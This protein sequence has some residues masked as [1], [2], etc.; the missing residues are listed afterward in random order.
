LPKNNSP[1][2][3]EAA[4]RRTVLT[5]AL[6]AMM[7]AALDSSIVNTA[8]PRMVADL[9]G[10]THLS[11][12]VTAFMLSSTIT[13]PLYGKLSDTHGRRAMFAVSIG[14][15][16]LGSVLCGAARTMVEL[17]AFRAV[18]G[19][20]AGGLLV[21]AQAMIGD[22]VSPRDRPRYQGLFTGVFGLA[23][24]LGPLLGG[25]ITQT[26][27]WR[28]IFYV[29]LPVG[30]L[31]FAMIWFG[32]PATKR[33]NG[34]SRAKPIDYLGTMLLT[35]LTTSLLLL[36]A[37][38]GSQFRWESPDAL[39]MCLVTVLCFGLFLWREAHAP[40]P[41]IRLAL[42]RNPVI[43]RGSAVGGMVM[44]A[45]FGSLVF[46][47]LYFQ[48]VLGMS[49]AESGAMI[50]PQVGCM[51]L[52]SVIGGRI[53]ARLGRYRPFLLAGI[54]LEM[55][56]LMSLAVFARTDAPP[57]LFLVT[58]GVFGLGMGMG[59]PNLTNA[60]QNAV[61]HAELGAAT[62]A[63]VFI[64]SLGGAVG[65]AASGA[66]MSAGLAGAHNGANLPAITAHGMHALTTLTP[67]QQTAI[68]QTYRGALSGS[69]L[70][71]SFVMIVA[72]ILL[73]GLPEIKLRQQI[74]DQAI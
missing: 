2:T 58:M 33:G 31:A 20:G 55:L 24:V 26:L 9:G 44:F 6:L 7:L 68:A 23:S 48:L 1:L 8:L 18:Q 4:N 70:L 19:L 64:R 38:G 41:V 47:P 30:T 3:K 57:S 21:L 43:A 71:S 50:L 35:G 61:A 59:M 56:A 63:M 53:V 12:V 42:F 10:L 16:L 5:G 52:S 46:M 73:L 45:M 49:P 67:A 69:F 66:I 15:F 14:I 17:I 25:I 39:I 60:I 27:S 51:F 29:N 54:G 74:E 36:L 62:G 65:V 13:T 28:W 11:W 32:L 34:Q 37:W 40:E 72:F 22:V